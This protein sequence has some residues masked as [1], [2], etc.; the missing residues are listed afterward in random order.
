LSLLLYGR[1]M[2][3]KW[4]WFIIFCLIVIAASDYAIMSTDK[5]QVEITHNM[6]R[7]DQVS[8]EINSAIC[9][10]IKE[11]D[12]TPADFPIKICKNRTHSNEYYLVSP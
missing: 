8:G 10:Y 7:V 2:K 9:F 5:P 6:Y 11:S 4:I 1:F 12:I 3:Y